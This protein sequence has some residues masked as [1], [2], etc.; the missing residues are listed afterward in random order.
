MFWNKKI[1]SPVSEADEAWV[2]ESLSWLREAFTE[3]HFQQISTI[4]PTT[5]FYNRTFDRSEEDAHFIL[6]R[7]K[8]LMSVQYDKIALDFYSNSP[9]KME[10]G[11]MLSTPA[12]GIDGS[13]DGA[14]GTYQ[15]DKEGNVIISIELEQLNDTISLIATIAHELAHEILLGEGWLEENDEYLTDLTAIFYGFGL[16]LGNSSFRFSQRSTAFGS[17]WQSS[18]QGYLPEQV[19]AYAMAWLSFERNEELHYT[20]FLS[21]SMK[22]YVEQA[23]KYLEDKHSE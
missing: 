21:K 8:E 4:T 3:E 18:R 15:Q 2:N 23:Y 9:T 14:A 22:K 1:K 6:E 16:F 5:N 13:W 17:E 11:T 12:A 10:D 19:I 20:Q 7:T